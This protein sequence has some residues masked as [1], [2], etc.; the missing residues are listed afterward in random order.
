MIPNWLADIFGSLNV[1]IPFAY[2][3][4]VM[5][6][7]WIGVHSVGTLYVFA[8]IYGCGSAGIQSL[9]QACINS[10]SAVPDL[11]KAGIRM[12]MAFSLVS[13]ACLTGA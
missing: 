8:A 12:G 5:M 11:K 2:L 3:C 4:G 13:F 10:L 1:L 6:F 7:A 9:W